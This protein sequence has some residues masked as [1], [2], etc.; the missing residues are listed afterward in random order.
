M[1]RTA[2]LTEIPAA[3]SS[4]GGEGKAADAFAF[5]RAHGRASELAQF[6]GGE[7]LGFAAADQE[8]AFGLQSRGTMQQR[9][10]ERLAGDFAAGDHILGGIAHGGIGTFDGYGGLAFAVI[11]F[12][13]IFLV[14]IKRTT[15]R[16]SVSS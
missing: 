15:T 7:I 4:P 11:F 12:A 16:Q 3:L 5:Q 10:F 14:T 2:S 8:Q 9:G 6:R 13:A 1:A